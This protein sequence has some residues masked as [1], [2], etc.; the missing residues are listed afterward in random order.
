MIFSKLEMYEMLAHHTILGP[1]IMDIIVKAF[2][3]TTD[4]YL[5]VLKAA[6]PYKTFVEFEESISAYFGED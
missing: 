1:D 5:K 2:G 6:T 4:T 3:N